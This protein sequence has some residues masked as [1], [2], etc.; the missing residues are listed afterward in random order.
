MVK[1]RY[2][3][4]FEFINIGNT[5]N[6]NTSKVEN[7]VSEVSVD[8]KAKEIYLSKI[9]TGEKILVDKP[10]FVIGKSS[11]CNYT[12]LGNNAVSRNHAEIKVNGNNVFI[13]D[14]KSTNKTFVNGK[15]IEPG[16]PVKIANGDELKFANAAFKLVL[17]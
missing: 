7:S 15:A 13:I 10:S 17:S 1:D 2:Y 5:G 8:N 3:N 4:P 11:E 14:K 12:I 16:K 9:D 6:L